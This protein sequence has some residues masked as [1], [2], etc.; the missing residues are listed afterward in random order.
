[1]DKENINDELNIILSE[2]Y[3][4]HIMKTIDQVSEKY[5]TS[6][7]LFKKNIEKDTDYNTNLLI[8]KCLVDRM[9]EYFTEFRD[10]IL[11]NRIYKSLKVKF[12]ELME[13]A[14]QNKDDVQV[15]KHVYWI[16]F[17]NKICGLFDDISLIYKAVIKS[18]GDID[19][20]FKHCLSV[21]SKERNVIKL[22]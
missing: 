12:K 16:K 9:S 4:K 20:L 13:F 6:F 15:G 5:T 17:Q 2:L 8:I 19:N 21:I 7:N 22:L 3:R 10:N 14:K 18:S 11:C 1:L